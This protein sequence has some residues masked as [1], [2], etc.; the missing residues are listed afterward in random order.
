M[1]GL[2]IYKKPGMT[3][4]QSLADRVKNS[5]GDGLIS[6]YIQA[7]FNAS[8]RRSFPRARDSAQH[9]KFNIVCIRL[10]SL[11]PSFFFTPPFGI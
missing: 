6:T 3:N 11:F 5:G 10:I 8:C 2:F 1:F 9:N 7:A 4:R